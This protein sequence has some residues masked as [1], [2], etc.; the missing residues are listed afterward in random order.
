MKITNKKLFVVCL[1]ALMA[2]C[3]TANLAAVP[4]NRDSYNRALDASENEQFLLSVVRMHYAE[5]PYFVSVDSITATTTLRMGVRGN[6]GPNNPFMGWSKQPAANAVSWSVAPDIGFTQSPTITYSP[7]QGA[8][9]ATGML[10]PLTM[11]KIFLLTQ[12]GYSPSEVMKLTM[13][14]VGSLLNGGISSDHSG[15]KQLPDTTAFDNHIALLDKLGAKNQIK[16]DYASYESSGAIYMSF[17]NPEAAASV[18]K[19]LGLS[20]SYKQLIFSN[21]LPDSTHP[22]NVISVYPR[23]YFNIVNFLARNVDTPQSSSGSSE[24]DNYAATLVDSSVDWRPYSKNLLHVL[25]STSEPSSKAVAKT[26]Y[27]DN[28]Y[29][30]ADNDQ[31]SKSTLVILKLI[32]SLQ[33][34]EVDANLPIITIQVN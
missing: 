11:G 31:V 34:G 28:W 21:L 1:V 27:N 4:Q 10:A 22:E 30:I 7:N 19:S 33:M 17:T 24:S 23:S 32:Y 26:E 15:S 25:T 20:K 9:F 13:N 29:Y 8:K 16:I 12:S 6:F 3:S 14:R 18:A 2:G 5:M